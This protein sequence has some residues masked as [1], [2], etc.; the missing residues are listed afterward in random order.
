V[1]APLGIV[2]PQAP[3]PGGIVIL[4]LVYG[5]GTAVPVLLVA[6]VLAYSVQA[7]GRI[8]HV[9]SKVE[10]WSRAVAGW[11]FVLLGLYFCLRYVLL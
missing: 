6:F 8:Y 1:L 11:L 2:L 7:V 3:L 9:L 4:P 5:L 10:W